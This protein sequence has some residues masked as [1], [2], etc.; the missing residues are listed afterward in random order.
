MSI[1]ILKGIALV[2]ML[3]HYIGAFIPGAP[4]L[5]QWIGKLAAPLFFYA[6]AWSMDKTHDKKAYMCVGRIHFSF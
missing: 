5:F 4:M 1:S 6:M 3:F 2:A